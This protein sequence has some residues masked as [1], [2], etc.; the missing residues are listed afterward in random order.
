M[1]CLTPGTPAAFGV[2]PPGPGA[3]CLLACLRAVGARPRSAPC[4]RS[5]R[6]APAS[7]RECRRSALSAALRTGSIAARLGRVDADREDHLAAVDQQCRRRGRRPS[8]S[9][10][11][12]AASPVR[13]RAGCRLGSGPRRKLRCW[14]T[15]RPR[16]LRM[17][18]TSTLALAALSSIASPVS[19][20]RLGRSIAAIGSVQVDH[21]QRAGRSAPF[22]ALRTRSGEGAFQAA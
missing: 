21:E 2:G 15:L 14:R 18:K 5:A 12:P 16:A 3:L 8:A 7:R 6:P 9:A 11:S 17:W 22:S 13:A 19:R 20:I 4:R 1:I 10:R